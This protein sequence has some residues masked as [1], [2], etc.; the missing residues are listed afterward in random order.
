MEFH[1]GW[2]VRR[3]AARADPTKG[4]DR[5]TLCFTPQLDDPMPRG[6]GFTRVPDA[7]AVGAE[8]IALG[9]LCDQTG[10]TS[11]ETPE[12]KILRRGVS[13][14]ELQ[15]S[16]ARGVTAINASSSVRVHQVELP[17]T[18]PFSKRPPKLLTPTLAPL[19]LRLLRRSETN[20][21]FRGV[22]VAEGRAF[23]TEAAPV[24][25][26]GLSIDHELRGKLSPASYTDQ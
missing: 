15:R 7:V 3:S 18:T 25:R 24:E 2:F 26:A 6:A 12:A 21:N 13:M 9:S 10:E 16:R 5:A 1:R 11:V 14:V 8:E 17:L 20:W 22:V 23:E 4:C 19:S